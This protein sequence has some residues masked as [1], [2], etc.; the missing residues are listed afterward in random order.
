M[1]NLPRVVKIPEIQ[2][3]NPILTSLKGS[4]EASVIA[5]MNAHQPIANFVLRISLAVLRFTWQ[6]VRLKKH[7]RMHQQHRHLRLSVSLRET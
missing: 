5:S 4:L 3:S 2:S 1:L 6:R 7:L